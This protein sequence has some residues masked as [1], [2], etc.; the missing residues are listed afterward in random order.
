[1][2]SYDLHGAEGID[3][4]EFGLRK[5]SVYGLSRQVWSKSARGVVRQSILLPEGVSISGI[6]LRGKN[7]QPADVFI[8]LR[9]PRV[10]AVHAAG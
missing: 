1:M 7:R 9:Q 3:S 5:S 2:V 4:A 10:V 8:R 6:T